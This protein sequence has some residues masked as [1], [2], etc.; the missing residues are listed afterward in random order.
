MRLLLKCCTATLNSEKETHMCS[1][2]RGDPDPFIL[3]NLGGALSTPTI[4]TRRSPDGMTV[5]E[6]NS[7]GSTP[8]YGKA[9]HEDARG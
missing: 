6:R 4:R 3:L 8:A 2:K 9:V 1:V 7:S 5:E